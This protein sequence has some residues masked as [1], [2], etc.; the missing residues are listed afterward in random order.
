[1]MLDTF[2]HC[3]NATPG[4]G[5]ATHFNSAGASLMPLAAHDAIRNHL[6]LETRVG[7]M[8]AA[9][10]AADAL[11][12]V[13]ESAA[14]LLGASSDE[15]ALMTSG[16]AAFGAVLSAMPPLQAGDRILVGRQE[17]GGNYASYER[18]ARRSGATVEQIPVKP[19]G[20]VDDRALKT[21]LDDRVR[22]ISLT[23]CPAN[24]GL[25]NDAE[26]VG[27]VARAARVPYWID[28]GQ[29]LGQIP[30]DVERLGCDVLKGA[31][32]KHLR[33]PRGTALLYVRKAYCEQ[34]EPSWVDVFSAPFEAGKYELQTGPRRFET[35]EKAVALMLGLGESVKLALEMG[36]AANLDYGRWL[37][38]QLRVRLTSVPG[39][40]LTDLGE[41][42]RSV[43]VSFRVTGHDSAS[44]ARYLG[45]QGVH[46]SW[47][48][49]AYTP[50]DMRARGMTDIVRAS[51]S[52][53]NTV[54]DID[55]MID[56]LSRYCANAVAG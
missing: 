4:W 46:V 38:D 22:L 37:A 40:E 47:N 52:Y 53:L 28:A 49:E 26:S 42:T 56:V 30:I 24:G 43:M 44:V 27:K 13:R 7:P 51:L 16:S 8:E 18:L 45:T 2:D 36:V 54:Q 15:I 17:W 35:S 55:R 11:N 6:D 12:G 5:N 31:G 3:R 32:R 21:M 29:A 14:R 34:L 9:V 10:R 41:G 39:V 19:D 25:I 1:M 33:G 48:G 50:L 23:W 20:G